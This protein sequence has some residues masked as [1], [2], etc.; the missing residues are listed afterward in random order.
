MLQKHL[1][2]WL[3]L[4]ISLLLVSY[5]SAEVYTVKGIKFSGLQRIKESTV[6]S[7][8]PIRVGDELENSSTSL[9]IR[10][11]YETGF[12]SE[13]NLRQENGI[14]YLE[15]VERPVI[16]AINISGN[17]KITKKQLQEALKS[18][19]ISEGLALD[20]SV[21]HSIKQAIIQQYYLM[22]IYEPSVNISAKPEA[23][24]R[25]SLVIA[26]KESS[27]AKIK[28]ITITGNKRF[29][30]STLLGEFSLSTTKLWSFITR[31]N[32]YSKEKLEADL[33]RLKSYYMDRG[34]LQVGI[35]EPKVQ[36]TPDKKSVYIG[37]N[38]HEGEIYRFR[39]FELSG[40]LLGKR[41]EIERLIGIKMGNIFSR[42]AVVVAQSRINLFMGDN[43]YGMATVKI[44]YVTDEKS[45]SVLVR[46]EVVA[47]P[48]VYVH[49]ISFVGNNKTHDRVLRQEM[50]LQ[51]GGLFS[52]SKINESRR[53]L[54]NLGY[55]QE[56]DYNITP[57]ADSNNQVDITYSFK[58]VS[59]IT[60]NVQAGYSDRDG[61]LYGASIV[62]QNV[63]GTGKSVFL[64]FDNSKATQS[65]GVGYRDPYFTADKIG[66]SLNGYYHKDNPNKVNS[67]LSAYKRD[68]YGAVASFDAPL[69]DYSQVAI[70]LGYE[71]IEIEDAFNPNI[72]VYLFTVENGTVFDQFKIFTTLSYNNLDRAIFPTEGFAH[73]LGLEGYGPLSSNSLFFYKT[74]Y[75]AIWY[76]PLFKEFIFRAKGEM[77]YGNGIGDTNLPFFKNFFAG[78]IGSVRGFEA[79][80]L[81]GEEDANRVIGGNL[82]TLASAS[83]IIPNPLNNSVRIS[84][85]VDVGNVYDTSGDRHFELNELRSSY[86]FQVEW[87]TPVA[88]FVFSFARPIHKKPWDETNLFQ[89][90]ISTSL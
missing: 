10:K 48:R 90:S 86:G 27:V 40:E 55:L 80:T 44:S 45:K 68:T 87:R 21:L 73:T 31:S 84:L 28:K 17:K 62:D 1:R 30:Q 89:F 53:R 60:L 26:I 39:G 63:F 47:G 22:G 83:L 34:Y 13:I 24:N 61:F 85:F 58:E 2:L 29:S 42:K 36:I 51:E 3:F 81:S 57:A 79:N 12:F 7:Y 20:E 82:L 64:Q 33:E 78:G 56:V 9:I 4:G 16:A 59:A 65:Y 52:V 14:L 8:L 37:I 35:D 11:L 72:K 66:L 19:G 71:H 15:V 50:R 69:S 23:R 49:R 41:K 70:G 25:V 67:D 6:L 77:G 76:F 32:V 38:I 46:F 43:G 75:T 5:A 88:P 54:A 74:D 18:V